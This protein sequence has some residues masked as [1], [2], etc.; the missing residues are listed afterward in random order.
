MSETRISIILVECILE[1]ID[2]SCG[3]KFPFKNDALVEA[4]HL[5]NNWQAHFISLGS[6]NE[7]SHFPFL[8]YSPILV[9]W[10]WRCFQDPTIRNEMNVLEREREKDR[11]SKKES[12][13][14]GARMALLSFLIAGR[15]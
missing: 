5:T 14:K 2:M 3:V 12:R 13:E 7:Y 4:K 11:R 9:A 1:S 6:R 15:S 8:F 10:I